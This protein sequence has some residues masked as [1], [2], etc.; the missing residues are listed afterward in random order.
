MKGLENEQSVLAV[1]DTTEVNNEEFREWAV[2]VGRLGYD[3]SQ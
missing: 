1:Q 2:S 3:G